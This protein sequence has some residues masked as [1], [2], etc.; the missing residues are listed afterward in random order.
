VVQDRRVK[1]PCRCGQRI[2]IL[3]PGHQGIEGLIDVSGQGGEGGQLSRGRLFNLVQVRVI[4]PQVGIDAVFQL[5]GAQHPVSGRRLFVLVLD[6]APGGAQ[7]IINRAI[8]FSHFQH[9]PHAQYL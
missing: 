8:D 1:P 9:L 6:G 7:H 5:R 3:P 4:V 2:G